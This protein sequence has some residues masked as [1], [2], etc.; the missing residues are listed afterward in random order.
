MKKPE[1]K[2]RPDEQELHMRHMQVR[3][4]CKTKRSPMLSEVCGVN[5]AG[6]WEE[7]ALACPR[8]ILKSMAAYSEY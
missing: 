2:F 8:M 4:V 1:T 6:I 7:E 5:E 3:R